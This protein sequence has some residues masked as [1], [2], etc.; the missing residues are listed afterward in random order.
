MYVYDYHCV[1]SSLQ[2]SLRS[3]VPLDLKITPYSHP[4]LLACCIIRYTVM[5]VEDIMTGVDR[6]GLCPQARGRGRAEDSSYTLVEMEGSG[7]AE[8]ESVNEYREKMMSRAIDRVGKMSREEYDKK[9]SVCHWL[10]RTHEPLP[11]A[12]IISFIIVWPFN[13]KNNLQRNQPPST[14]WWALF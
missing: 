9:V 6:A 3:W 14:F 13:R 12:F 11:P 5:V 8:R 4:C 2:H 10:S 1:C 7:V